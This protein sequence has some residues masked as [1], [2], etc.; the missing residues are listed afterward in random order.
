MFS[1]FSHYLAF[2]STDQQ[3][4]NA[5][6]GEYNGLVV[7]GTVA[8]FRGEGTKGF[9][10]AL[11]ASLSVPYA[12]DPRFPL[13]QNDLREPKKSH[14]ALARV[15]GIEDLVQRNGGLPVALLDDELA[16]AI[17][18]RWVR[19]NTGFQNLAP[20]AFDKYARR[21]K[22]PLPQIQANGPAQI[23]AP[24]LMYDG[25]PETRFWSDS[26]WEATKSAAVAAGTSQPV[27]RVLAVKEPK[28]LSDLFEDQHD[29]DV[30]IWVNNLEEPKSTPYR[31]ADYAVEVS[32]LA[33][34]GASPFALYGGYF[35][36]MLRAVGL[37]GIS[38]GVGFSE[39]RNYIELKSSGG[40]PA[41]YYVRKLHRYLPV[42]LASEIW[43][44]R[45]E[46]V[47]DPE[48]PMGLMDPAELDYQ[49][50]M[51]H[52]VLA[53]AAEIRESTGFGLVDHIHELEVLYKRFSDGVATIRL[54]TG[55]EKRAKENAGHLLQWKQ[56]LE[57][58]LERVR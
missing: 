30:V 8:A 22:K 27:V 28:L 45:P 20:K 40:A 33:A 16:A 11:S 52:S 41:R 15:L 25:A 44:R 19:F 42:D 13:F 48:T 3:T 38:H 34:Q 32:Q 1:N 51:K 17:A 26:L 37:K 24:Y 39:H 9:V 56:A 47:D 21:L 54:T 7:P 18:T 49:A 50:L 2:G 57:E 31:L 43:R 10:L 5:L 58:A 53:R 36:V 6:A 4:L 55:L 12:V 23:M 29:P 46:L 14:L 35:A